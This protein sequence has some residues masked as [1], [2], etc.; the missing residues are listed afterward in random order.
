M[1][2]NE[3]EYLVQ[4]SPPGDIIP[5]MVRTLVL[6]QNITNAAILFDDSFGKHLNT[7]CLVLLTKRTINPVMDHKYKALLQ[8]VATRHLIDEINEDVN[9][10]PDHLESLVKLDL[11]NFF[12]LGNLQSIKKVLEAAEK[13]N[14]FN[15]MFAWHVLTKVPL[16]IALAQHFS[17]SYIYFRIQ[18]I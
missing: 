6:N 4:I 13:K 17:N 7:G 11:K 15:R 9:K 12:V 1:K 16:I 3:E 18:R 14:L 8:N 5:E 10:I 2:P